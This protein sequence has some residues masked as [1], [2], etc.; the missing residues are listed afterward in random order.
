MNLTMPS[1]FKQAQFV[2]RMNAI[3][4]FVL[5]FKYA[6][7]FLIPLIWFGFLLYGTLFEISLHRYFT[8]RSFKTSKYKEYLLRFI[9]FLMGQ[10]SILGWITVH[11]THHR[12]ADTEKDPHSPKHMPLWRVLTAS[13]GDMTS[14]RMIMKELKGPD[15]EYLKWEA[16]YYAFLW[17]ALWI[18]TL[19]ISP[20]LLFVVAGGATIQIISVGLL[21]IICHQYGDKPYENASAYNNKWLNLLIGYANHNSHHHKPSSSYHKHDHVGF[22]INKFFEDVKENGK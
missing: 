5:L 17:S 16:R 9:A 19:S 8:H 14:P 7:I 3:I 20:V 1:A 12:Y 21:N 4:A 6:S 10:G 2:I 15:A 18:L 22:I 11:R 13:Y